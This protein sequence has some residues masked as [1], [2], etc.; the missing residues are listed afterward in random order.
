MRIASPPPI[1][2]RFSAPPW[3]ENAPIFQMAPQRRSSNTFLTLIEE[4]LIE[5]YS[6]ARKRDSKGGIFIIVHPREEENEFLVS[7]EFAAST[8]WR[9]KIPAA[10]DVGRD[11]LFISAYVNFNL[12]LWGVMSRINLYFFGC[13]EQ[14]RLL[15][16]SNLVVENEFSSYQENNTDSRK[17]ILKLNSR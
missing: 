17:I 12:S 2:R 11:F 8:G 15:L 14:L 3:N 1:L 7:V 6:T 16:G 13:F 5:E 4:T 10:R 9:R